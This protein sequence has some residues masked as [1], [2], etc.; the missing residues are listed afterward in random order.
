MQGDPNRVFQVLANLLDN[1]VK[2]TDSGS[3]ELA[4]TDSDGS[5]ERVCFTVTDTGIGMS[6]GQMDGLFQSF[7]QADPSITRRYGGTG[8]G[9]AI[10][11]KLVTLMGGHIGVTSV[12]GSGSSLEV[13][14][15]RSCPCVRP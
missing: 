13:V 14:L 7:S 10:C 15:P 8:L 5:G 4:V 2:F 9:L 12:E 1:A 6:A 3:V 11:K